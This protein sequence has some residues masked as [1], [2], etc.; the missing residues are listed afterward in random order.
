MAFR[1][2]YRTFLPVPL[3]FSTLMA[4]DLGIKKNRL[5]SDNYAMDKYS[6]MIGYT[7]LGI[8]SGITY[9]VSFPLF[10]CYILGASPQG[11]STPRTPH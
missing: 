9:P 5:I 10:G 1:Q 11:V 2:L 8:L 3:I 7:T 4:I 6:I